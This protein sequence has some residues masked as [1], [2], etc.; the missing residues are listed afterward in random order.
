MP[1]IKIQTAP[2]DISASQADQL[3][4]R[5]TDLMTE[6]MGKK[7]ERT[8]V[9]IQPEDASLWAVGGKRISEQDGNAVYMEIKV[10]AGTNY[11]GDKEEMVLRSQK[12]LSE[13]LNAIPEATYIVI[14]E[15]LGESWG[16]GGTMMAERSAADRKEAKTAHVKAA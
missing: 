9:H 7:R 1:F 2:G 10:T 4:A 3:I 5:T 12:M 14:E 13:V 15:I 8:T 16:K 6:V 11:T